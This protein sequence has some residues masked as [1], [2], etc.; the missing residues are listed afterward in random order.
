MRENAGKMRTGITP[1]TVTFY[2]VLVKPVD[3]YATSSWLSIYFSFRW[4]YVKEKERKAFG[5]Y[6]TVCMQ[7]SCYKKSWIGECTTLTSVFA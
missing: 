7:R 2:A 3:Q 1:N 5:T 6:I 4:V